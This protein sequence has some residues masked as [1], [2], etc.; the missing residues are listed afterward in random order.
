MDLPLIV[1]VESGKRIQLPSDWLPELT[2]GGR[3]VLERTP[4]GILVRPYPV[5]GWDEVFADKL[6]VGQTSSAPL[7]EVTGRP[8]PRQTGPS[9]PSSH[10]GANGVMVA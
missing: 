5:V 7:D 8:S 6:P 9:G 3:V 10:S 2:P 4:G 1:P